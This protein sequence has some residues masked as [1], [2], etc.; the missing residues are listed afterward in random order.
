MSMLHPKWAAE[1]GKAQPLTREGVGKLNNTNT[2]G[3]GG[4]EKLNDLT[5]IENRRRGRKVIF[6]VGKSIK[7]IAS[8]FQIFCLQNLPGKGHLLENL[9]LIHLTPEN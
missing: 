2:A 5:E 7:K 9:T 1:G 3:W 8:F 4:A 6:P